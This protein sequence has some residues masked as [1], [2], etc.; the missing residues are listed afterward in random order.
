MNSSKAAIVI[1]SILGKIASIVGFLF[2]GI[3]LLGT[4]LL[5]LD[6]DL[7]EFGAGVMI[8]IIGFCVFL[9]I[10]GRRIKTRIRRFRQ[11]VS[12]IS[13]HNMTSIDLLA[14]NTKQTS[15][16]VK[17]DL[18]TMINKRFFTNARIDSATNSIVIQ[19]QPPAS[20]VNTQAQAQ[21]AAGVQMVTF[22]CRGCGASG[23]KPQGASA[24]CEYCGS[25]SV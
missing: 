3:M 10:V 7:D 16:F 25:V 9:I 5:F 14:S 20:S 4:I 15:A 24:H 2:G 23:T 11:Y 1:S 18:Q 8:V 13:A 21:P 19:G 6:G 22:S 12:L 17:A